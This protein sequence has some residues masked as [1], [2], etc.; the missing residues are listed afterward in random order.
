MRQ[1]DRDGERDYRI[2]GLTVAGLGCLEES[3]EYGNSLVKKVAVT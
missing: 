1:E 2:S 3:K